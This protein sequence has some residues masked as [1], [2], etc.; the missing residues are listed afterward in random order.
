MD[1]WPVAVEQHHGREFGLAT[2]KQLKRKT[3]P[4][5]PDIPFKDMPHMA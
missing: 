2:W 3:P 1:S 5:G 4:K